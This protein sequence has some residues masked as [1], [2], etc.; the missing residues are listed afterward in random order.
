MNIP[1]PQDLPGLITFWIFLSWIPI[2]RAI[3]ISVIMRTQDMLEN[4]EY[5]EDISEKVDCYITISVAVLVTL[6]FWAIATASLLGLR[7]LIQMIWC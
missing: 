6:I 4:Y 2:L 7:L 3:A 5:D 1:I